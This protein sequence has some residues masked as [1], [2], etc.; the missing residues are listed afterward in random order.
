MVIEESEL[1]FSP[2]DEDQL[3]LL[4]LFHEKMDEINNCRIIKNDALR[5]SVHHSMGKDGFKVEANLPDQDD[6]RS[7]SS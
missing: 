7:H 1:K 6:L 4:K 2:L 3:K 5:G